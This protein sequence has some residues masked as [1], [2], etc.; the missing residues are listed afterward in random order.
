MPSLVGGLRGRWRCLNRPLACALLCH[1]KV[2]ER[3]AEED[4]RESVGEDPAELFVPEGEKNLLLHHREG[5]ARYVASAVY[6]PGSGLV[7]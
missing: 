5:V 7:V 6:A 4:L 1:R 3:A 2:D